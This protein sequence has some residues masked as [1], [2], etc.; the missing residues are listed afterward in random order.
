MKVKDLVDVVDCE[1]IIENEK[2]TK[3][4]KS[5]ESISITRHY[6]GDIEECPKELLEWDV[7]ALDSEYKDIITIFV[8]IPVEIDATEVCATEEKG[9]NL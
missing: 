3:V 8:D 1:V 4:T 7:Y 6:R 2:V 5:H 9:I